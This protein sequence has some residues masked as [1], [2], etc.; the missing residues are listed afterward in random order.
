MSLYRHGGKGL[1]ELVLATAA[2]LVLSPLI[3]LVDVAQEER[4]TRKSAKSMS[5]WLK[6]KLRMGELIA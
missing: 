5:L 6:Q 4:F 1:L 2:C 3:L